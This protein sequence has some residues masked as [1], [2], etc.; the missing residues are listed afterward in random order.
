MKQSLLQ[1]REHVWKAYFANER[2]YLEQVLPEELITIDPGNEKFSNRETILKGA[3]RFAQSGSKLVKL[4]FPATELQTYGNVVLLYSTYNATLQTP[5]G[6]S[7]MS[8]RATETF[9]LRD[10]KWLNV[11]WHFDSAPAPLAGSS[12]SR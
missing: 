8:G 7:H 12:G 11:G 5:G 6:E 10:G 9:V 1:A 2:P 3:E 4:E